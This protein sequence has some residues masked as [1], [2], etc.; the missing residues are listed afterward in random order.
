M[1]VKNIR[2]WSLL[3]SGQMNRVSFSPTSKLHYHVVVIRY[4]ALSTGHQCM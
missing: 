4:G 1:Y 3:K 2:R